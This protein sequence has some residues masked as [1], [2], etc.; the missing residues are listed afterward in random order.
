MARKKS[1]YNRCGHFIPLFP[2]RFYLQEDLV[3]CPQKRGDVVVGRIKITLL[4]PNGIVIEVNTIFVED[5][6]DLQA[7]NPVWFRCKI[8]ITTID[9]FPSIP[10]E[11]LKL[12]PLTGNLLFDPSFVGNLLT[13]PEATKLRYRM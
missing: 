6:P 2:G 11:V 7:V 10:G 3:L 5:A 12:L 13:P 9:H 1:G 4:A 8:K